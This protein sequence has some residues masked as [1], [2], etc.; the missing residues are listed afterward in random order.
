MTVFFTNTEKNS[1]FSPNIYFMPAFQ[2]V[3][4]TEAR[5]IFKCI[6]IYFQL[7][8]QMYFH[9]F[10]NPFSDHRKHWDEG[11]S[12]KDERPT[13]ADQRETW[14]FV[15]YIFKD[16]VIVRIKDIVIVIVI[17]L[18]KDVH[19][20]VLLACFFL[21]LNYALSWFTRFFESHHAFDE[22]SMKANN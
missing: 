6:F 20:P 4:S 16:T 1:M 3:E 5:Y 13:T 14:V 15:I 12:W 2:I 11:W 18:F 22:L 19:E 21:L 10:P 9:I 17:V 8:F 7:Y